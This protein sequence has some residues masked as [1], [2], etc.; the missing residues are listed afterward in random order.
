MSAL[1]EGKEKH[2]KTE[3]NCWLLFYCVKDILSY[4]GPLSIWI[5]TLDQR[6][7]IYILLQHSVGFFQK[8]Y[9]CI[10]Q[11]MNKYLIEKMSPL[12]LNPC[13]HQWVPSAWTKIFQHPN[14]H[15][16]CS[17]FYQLL[18]SSHFKLFINYNLLFINH[19]HF[20]F[21]IIHYPLLI[22]NLSFFTIKFK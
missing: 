2:F 18:S 19:F 16:S 3:I 13:L 11:A 4:S 9:D 6:N 21:F 17:K 7:L 22:I 14:I 5:A 15:N 10:F 20:S 12:N 8:N 1:L